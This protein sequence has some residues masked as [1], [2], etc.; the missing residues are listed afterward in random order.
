MQSTNY[1]RKF[2]FTNTLTSGIILHNGF[3]KIF[4]DLKSSQNITYKFSGLDH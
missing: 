1:E 4:I 3:L 2:R